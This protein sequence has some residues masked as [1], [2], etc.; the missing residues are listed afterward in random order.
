MVDSAS[1]SKIYSESSLYD[2]SPE[3][4]KMVVENFLKNLQTE[5]N[6]SDAELKFL[7]YSKEKR[8][9]AKLLEN[10]VSSTITLSN[11]EEIFYLQDYKSS[12]GTI[13]PDQKVRNIR[14]KDESGNIV[15]TLQIDTLSQKIRIQN[16][17]NILP[18]LESFS[19]NE[20]GMKIQNL[21]K[22]N[23]WTT[24]DGGENL[25][26][27]NREVRYKDKNGNVMAAIIT[28]DNGVFDT[29]AEYE[30]KNGYRTKMTLTNTYGN[31][32]V[33]YDGTK[34]VNQVVRVDIDNDGMIN[35]ITKAYSG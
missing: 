23:K 3:S 22:F 30:Y 4:N 19:P 31:S 9:S 5:G 25:F 32:I 21:A 2:F 20:V 18:R 28:N 11:Y 13:N 34:Q 10:I 8:S 17:G 1:A 24:E 6:L 26:N 27:R 33:I 14:Y 15:A 7:S 16:L 35:E 12:V 29:I